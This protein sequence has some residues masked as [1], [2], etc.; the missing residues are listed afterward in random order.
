MPSKCGPLHWPYPKPIRPP[1]WP[2]VAVA[3]LIQNTKLFT[4]HTWLGADAVPKCDWATRSQCHGW[5]TPFQ[6]NGVHSDLCAWFA[7]IFAT[8]SQRSKGWDPSLTAKN[9]EFEFITGSCAL[10]FIPEISWSFVGLSHGI[11]PPRN[12]KLQ[13][14]KLKNFGIISFNI[15]EFW[16]QLTTVMGA[17]L[18]ASIRT[19]I[20]YIFM[21]LDHPYC[22]SPR[23][24]I[25]FHH[26]KDVTTKLQVRNELK[27]PV[28]GSCWFVQHLRIAYSVIKWHTYVYSVSNDLQNV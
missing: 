7:S 9:G 18:Q 6:R 21:S 14:F 13:H 1:T 3:S 17:C 8:G 26:C 22:H 23:N 11:K 10:S 5:W 19:V 24:D 28:T 16:W 20:W 2:H 12:E 15:F 4:W 25:L 27:R